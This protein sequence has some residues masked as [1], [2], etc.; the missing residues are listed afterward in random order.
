MSLFKRYRHETDT[1]TVTVKLDA[2]DLLAKLSE[3]RS[4]IET[5][6]AKMAKQQEEIEQLQQLVTN[7]NEQA[8]HDE[9]VKTYVDYSISSA[10]ILNDTVNYITKADN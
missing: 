10:R 6:S 2:N 7:N 5:V 4:L 8:E 3:Q 1:P 9:R